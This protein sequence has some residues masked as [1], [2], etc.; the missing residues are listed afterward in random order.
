MDRRCREAMDGAHRCG[1]DIH[2][3]AVHEL[4][5]LRWIGELPRRYAGR[6]IFVARERAELRFDPHP[7]IV[8]VGYDRTGEC[9]VFGERQLRTVDHH[10]GISRRQAVTNLLQIGRVV[11]V[12]PDRHRR[13]T[14]GGQRRRRKHRTRRL[15]VGAGT[16]LQNDRQ[17]SPFRRV[18]YSPDGLQGIDGKRRHRPAGGSCLEN[19]R[20]SP[21]QHHDLPQVPAVMKPAT[22]LI[23]KAI[24]APTSHSA[25]PAEASWMA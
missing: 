15:T 1:E 4:H 13:V 3:G 8:C 17:A 5:R 24:K 25:K 6:R 11:Q 16:G 2:T 19:E 21:G 10:R 23:R 7:G 22:S 14:G 9:H 18:T 20:W 12:D